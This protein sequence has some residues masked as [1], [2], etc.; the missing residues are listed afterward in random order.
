MSDRTSPNGLDARNTFFQQLLA[1]ALSLGNGMHP[2][3]YRKGFYA[4]VSRARADAEAQPVPP[5]KN[6]VVRLEDARSGGEARIQFDHLLLDDGRLKIT[7]AIVRAFKADATL[8]LGE[9]LTPTEEQWKAILSPTTSAVTIGIA[10][11]GKTF[12]MMMR[13]ILLHCYLQIPLEEMTI[14][15]VT[16]D[17]RFDVITDLTH[18]MSR[19]GVSL[20]EEQSLSLVRTPRGALLSLIRS[21]PPLRDVVPFELLG[22]IDQG[23]EDGRP[24]DL[25][26]SP[27]QLEMVIEAY[28]GAYLKSSS[29]ARSIRVHFADSVSLP[30]ASSDNPTLIRYSEQG[31]SQ[32]G[33]DET[34]TKAVTSLWHA[35][36]HWPIPEIEA[37]L[38]PL[39]VMGQQIQVNGYMPVLDA[40]VILGTP[41]GHSR[42]YSRPGTTTPLFEECLAKRA[43]IQRFCSHRV[44]WCETHEQ[45]MG[46]VSSASS[47]NELAPIFNARI[48]GQERPMTIVECLY[49]T[50]SL[51]ETLGLDPAK[52]IADLRFM[53]ND[54]DALFFDCA[55]KFWPLFESHLLE[56]QPKIMSFN[57]LFLTFGEQGKH[58]LK[59]VPTEALRGMQNVLTDELQDVTVH[60]GE[61]IKACMVETR[62]RMEIY[63]MPEGVASIFACG[64]DFQTAH[65]TQGATP[66]Y[67]VDFKRHF[68]SKG[69]VLN[70]LGV[71]F[72][73]QAGIIFAA[74]SLV[75]GIPAV[76]MQAPASA[77]N[78]ENVPV[79]VLEL[80]AGTFMSLFD[81][82]YAAGDSILILAASPDDY[83]NSEGFVNVAVDRD[84]AENPNSR[85]VRVRA[86]QRSKGL[87]ADTVFII[88]D[89]TAATSTWAKNQIF[90]SANTVATEDQSPFD[91]IQENELYR[92]CHIA[93]TRARYRCYWM[94]GRDTN[95]FSHRLK[96]SSR[97][98][99]VPGSFLDR[100]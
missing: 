55:A 14:L 37:Q 39:S 93:I 35:A 62:H 16:K 11:T 12:V 28:Q 89:F 61:F 36:G 1:K 67:L 7:P 10:G 90:R 34:L 92:S 3:S 71:N 29:F 9:D 84:K 78:D 94:I 5:P 24:F 97:V 48:K 30:R 70:L 79:E 95:D 42:D 85:R 59:A 98:A 56:R 99:K 81:Q 2:A 100:R 83:R 66:Q 8:N 22:I 26:L 6:I 80:S 88:G 75:Q 60:T 43:F 15:A 53:A 72:R 63:D 69:F 41:K 23:D 4:G 51:I 86:A 13:A 45:L 38:I 82:H 64:D 57:R 68:P 49:Q 96:A 46:I 91:V 58:N 25:R 73:S 40:Y 20:S 44:I 52:A 21:V 17:C 54:P 32:I 31:T 77:T 65:G 74:Q 27:V 47:L 18:L 19:W 76:S 50:G 87:E 33:A